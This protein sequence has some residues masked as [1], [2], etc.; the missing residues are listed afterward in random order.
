M[1]NANQQGLTCDVD[2]TSPL[3]Y[4]SKEDPLGIEEARAKIGDDF[5][6][7]AALVASQVQL[8]AGHSFRNDCPALGVRHNLS[9]WNGCA[10][11]SADSGLGVHAGPQVVDA[12]DEYQLMIEARFFHPELH[13]RE[14]G[15]TARVTRRYNPGYGAALWVD[16]GRPFWGMNKSLI[17]GERFLSRVSSVEVLAEEVVR[18]LNAAISLRMVRGASK[19]ALATAAFGRA[20]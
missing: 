8:P 20:R 12:A 6:H 1:S 4:G 18:R 5:T 16:Q 10:V 7:F 9:W 17:E 14:K 3:G 2:K 15:R 11:R 19:P 13:F